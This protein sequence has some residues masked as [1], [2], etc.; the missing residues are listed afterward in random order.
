MFS[1]NPSELFFSEKDRQPTPSALFFSLF[2]L[3]PTRCAE[4]RASAAVVADRGV[5]R[6]SYR[7]AAR[8][9]VRFNQIG[10]SSSTLHPISAPPSFEL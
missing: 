1:D 10:R 4:L 2:T 3:M 8:R 6:A 9:R 7:D 5:A